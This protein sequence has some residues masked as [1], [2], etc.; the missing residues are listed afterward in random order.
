MINEVIYD[1]VFL[2]VKF[3]DGG[4]MMICKWRSVFVHADYR[5]IN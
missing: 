3:G 4:Q 2:G 5:Y 1:L